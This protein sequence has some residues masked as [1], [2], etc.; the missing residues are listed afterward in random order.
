MGGTG[1]ALDETNS[2][3]HGGFPSGISDAFGSGL[4]GLDYLEHVSYY[5][6]AMQIDFTNRSLNETGTPD[7]AWYA[8]INCNA[9]GTAQEVRPLYYGMYTF[10]RASQA[11]NGGKL[12][13]ITNNFSGTVNCSIMSYLRPDG[14][15]AVVIDNKDAAQSVTDTISFGKPVA[16]AS[17]LALTAPSVGSLAPYVRLGGAQIGLDGTFNPTWNTLSLSSSSTVTVTVPAGSA[18]V[19]VGTMGRGDFR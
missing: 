7:Q 1:F 18:L 6:L 8:P 19:V 3:S 13:H 16:S 10:M 12:I 4:W 5:P 9:D 17:S 11:A 15:V 14:S 2:F